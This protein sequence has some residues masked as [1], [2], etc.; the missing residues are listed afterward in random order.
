MRFVR[1]IAATMLLALAACGQSPDAP[2]RNEAALTA[3][4]RS[5]TEKAVTGAQQVADQ[6]LPGSGATL[7]AFRSVADRFEL[8]VADGRF[9]E[10]APDAAL[11]CKGRLSITVPDDVLAKADTVAAMLGKGNLAALS[12]AE[13]VELDGTTFRID[14]DYAVAA[15]GSGQVTEPERGTYFVG[16]VRDL[17]VAGA[18]EPYIRSQHDAMRAEKQARAEAQAIAADPSRTDELEALLE[19]EQQLHAENGGDRPAMAAESAEVAAR[20]L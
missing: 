10:T 17:L 16:L 13:G 20:G 18:L 14:V 19:R 15:D 1:M 9:V 3:L 2:C 6:R 12:K 11:R 7:S 8:S 5:I 4:T